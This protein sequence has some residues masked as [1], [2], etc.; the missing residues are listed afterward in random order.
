MNEKPSATF[1]SIIFFVL[2][3]I[4][5][6][7]F[8]YL[9]QVFFF[10]IFWAILITGFF[11]PLNKMLLSRLKSPNLCASITLVVVVLCLILPAGLLISLLINEFIE[12]YKT[13][14]SDTSRWMDTLTALINYLDNHPLFKRLDINQEFFMAKSAEILNAASEF[15]FKNLSAVTQNTVILVIQ[16]AVMFYS[17]FF[18]LRDGDKFINAITHYISVDKHRLDAFIGNFLATAKATLKVTF[19]IGGI[20]GFLG[21][22][23][24]YITGIEG[25]LLWGVIM[26]GLS[27]VPAVGCSL[28]WAPAGI[29]MLVQ[30]HLWQGATILLFG[31]F[32]ISTVDNILRPILVGHDLHMHPLLVFLSTLGGLAVFGVS[33]F[34]LG[35]VIASLF[36]ASW[37]L[38]LELHKKEGAE[39]K[40]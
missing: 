7:F 9:L 36:L 13:V 32:V 29:I 15:I 5:T 28:V 16:F 19:V 4:V 24:F 2:L 21:G 23:I 14:D 35:P 37:K 30:G 12:I 22:L 8:G 38:F 20:Q 31:I 33:G 27:I 10:A 18:F 11:S 40:I 17:L 39:Q 6:F 34:V 26:T 1:Q 3:G 25:A